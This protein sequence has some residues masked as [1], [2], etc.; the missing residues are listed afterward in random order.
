MARTT[1][2]A[3]VATGLAAASVHTG[4][5]A[6]EPAAIPRE[7]L[8]SADYRQGMIAFQ[9]RCS[10]CHSAADGGLDLVGPNLYGVFSRKVGMKPGYNFSD[11]LRKAG[12]QWTPARLQAWLADP[13]GYLPGNRM[14]VP[15]AVPPGDRV[16]L[17]SYLMLETGAADWPKPEIPVASTA[18]SGRPPG[19]VPLEERFPSFWN[20]LM[21]NTTRYRM[22]S[23]AGELKFDA[24]FEADGSIAASIEAIRGFWHA[25]DRDMFCYALYNIPLAPGQ[26]VECFPIAAMSIPRF[27]EELWK[28]EPVAGVKLTGGIVA[29]RPT[30]VDADA[31]Y[32]KNLFANTMRYEVVVD[33]A[34]QVMDLWFNEDKTVTSNGPARGTWLVQ[35]GQGQEEMCYAVTGLPGLDGA[36]EECFP[37][38]LMFN[39]RIGARWPSKFKNGMGYWCEVVAGRDPVAPKPK[40]GPPPP[41]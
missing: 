24:Y 20:H 15:E 23:A 28:S 36:L 14:T 11:A 29:G 17:L 2:W 25:D 6:A 35:G 37:L 34:P 4:A 26:L 31:G 18:A 1:L 27:R 39:P 12:F 8:V 9:Q 38:R 22:E 16:A 21:T 30:G 5:L 33:G 3:M 40:P 19:S 32:W 10:A 7:A 13:E 41:G